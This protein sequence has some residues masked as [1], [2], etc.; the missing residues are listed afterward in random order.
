MNRRIESK[1]SRT[2]EFTCLV[3]GLSNLEKREHYKSDD[4][5]SMIIMN[6]LIRPLLHF[7]FFKKIFMGKYPAGMYEYVIARTKTIDAEFKRAL[8]QGIKQILIFGAGFDSRG[9]RLGSKVKDA[10][11]FELDA[12]LTQAAKIERYRRKKVQIPGSLTYIPIDFDR[13]SLPERLLQEGFEKGRPSLFILEGLTM[14][15]QPGSVDG[16]FRVIE[17]FSGAGS[18]V[19]FDHIYASVLRRENLYEGEEALYKGVADNGERFCFGI[20]KGHAD[21]FLGAY[22]FTAEKVLD[23]SGLEDMYFRDA[24]G[25]LLGRVNQTH[26]IVTAVKK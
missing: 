2:A 21:E 3:R 4:D 9:V 12:P 1:M 6:D 22:G 23:A 20:E 15:L 25:E 18:R 11:I 8:D 26:C 16:T 10:R 24:S 17:E 7:S 5:V 13:E 14:Y 19:V